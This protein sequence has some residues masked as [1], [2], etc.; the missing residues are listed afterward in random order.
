MRI[1]FLA[2]GISIGLFVSGSA[3]GQT[4]FHCSQTSTVQE[5]LIREAQVRK[6]HVRRMEVSG[7][8]FTWHKEFQKRFWL[9]E[10]DLFTRSGLV[11]TVRNVSRI[12]TIY[13]V[14]LQDVKILLDRKRHRVDLIF[15]VME[16]PRQNSK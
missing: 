3:N 12:R 14:G 9:D 8:T 16:R 7:A 10:G 1:L 4:P 11:K 15:C 13:P 2:A 5:E 6:F